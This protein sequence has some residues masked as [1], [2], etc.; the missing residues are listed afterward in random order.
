MFRSKQLKQFALAG[1]FTFAAVM[2]TA[3]APPGYERWVLPHGEYGTQLEVPIYTTAGG[4]FQAGK[5]GQLIGTPGAR[6]VDLEI[7]WFDKDPSFKDML[8]EK[9]KLYDISVVEVPNEDDLAAEVWGM[10]LDLFAS[11]V[12]AGVQDNQTRMTDI[13]LYYRKDPYDGQVY[14]MYAGIWVLNKGENQSDWDFIPP[15]P[16]DNF[17]ALLDAIAWQWRPYDIEFAQDQWGNVMGTALLAPKGFFVPIGDGEYEEYLEV[18]TEL[19][20]FYP[21]ELEGIMDEGWQLLDVEVA[22]AF[23]DPLATSAFD[24]DVV[25]M[26][27]IFVQVPWLFDATH[28]GTV[29]DLYESGLD[30]VNQDLVGQARLIDLEVQELVK[31]STC[32]KYGIC[33]GYQFYLYLGAWLFGY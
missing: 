12:F 23:P 24:G 2:P 17:M 11:D 22:L 29:P 10:H 18:P 9:H 19:M 33:E 6:P 3:A 28:V 20:Y 4:I 14:P 21:N 8:N 30:D 32:G 16:Y 1:L 27:G 31:G 13:E 25:R 5:Y 26:F 15:M 7:N